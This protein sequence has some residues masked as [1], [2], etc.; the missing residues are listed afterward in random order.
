MHLTGKEKSTNRYIQ[1]KSTKQ[2][3]LRG[4]TVAARNVIFEDLKIAGMTGGHSLMVCFIL[5]QERAFPLIYFNKQCNF[6]GTAK[7]SIQTEIPMTIF[8]FPFSE[9]KASTELCK[10]EER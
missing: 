6:I 3:C 9:K 5:W 10:T 2:L 8:F 7:I 4:T 1:D